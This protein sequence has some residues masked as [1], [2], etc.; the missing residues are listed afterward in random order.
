MTRVSSHVIETRSCDWFKAKVNKFFENGD[1]LYREISGRDYGIDGIIELFKNG[2]PT[3]KFA[4]VQIK[5]TK[6]KITPMKRTSNYVSCKVSSSNAK[7]AFQKNIPVI[8]AYIS[9][10]S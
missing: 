3:G 9:L 6:S 7:Y 2:Q 10:N 4:L 8:L 5:G 1:A